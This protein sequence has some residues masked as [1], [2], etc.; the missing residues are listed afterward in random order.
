VKTKQDWQDAFEALGKE[1]GDRG[2][3]RFP[4]VLGISDPEP[5]N[6]W[7][8]EDAKDTVENLL[9]LM[10]DEAAAQGVKGRAAIESAVATLVATHTYFGIEM[11]LWL[12][13]QHKVTP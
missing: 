8:T 3:D 4:I 2:P 12:V 1:R 7:I 9:W 5:L 11:G 6:Q 13:Q 10:V